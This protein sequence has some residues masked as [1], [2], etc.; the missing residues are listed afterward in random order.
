[1]GGWAPG[2]QPAKLPDGI[3][4]FLPANS[5]IVMQVHYH[6]NGRRAP[7]RSSF[8]LYFAAPESVSKRLVTIPVVNTTFTIPPGATAHEVKASLPILPFLTGKAI[9]V[10]PHMHLLGTKIS[11][12]LVLRDGTRTPL[13][14]IDQWDFKWQ[15]FYMF[16]EAVTLPA[17]ATVQLSAVYDN[18]GNNPNNPN[19]PLK[20]VRWGEGTDD[21]M[22]LGFLG[23]VFDNENLIPLSNR[24]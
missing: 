11:M 9:L 4:A 18:S 17:G 15:G 5:R 23:M 19:N 7:D 20:P 16:R 14:H 24:R 2:A 21:E 3:A 12:D 13:V 22:C 10:A 6:P 8:G 1:L